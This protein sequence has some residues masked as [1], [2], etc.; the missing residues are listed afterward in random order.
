MQEEI[1]NDILIQ[2]NTNESHFSSNIEELT[3]PQISEIRRRP[4]RNAQ[5]STLNHTELTNEVLLTVKDHFK[6]PQIRDDRFDV[7][8]KNVAIKLRDLS[9]PQRIH[10]EKLINDVLYEGEMGSLTT[11]HKLMVHEPHNAFHNMFRLPYPL[12]MRYDSVTPSTNTSSS[13]I[14]SPLPSY[15]NLMVSSPRNQYQAQDRSFVPISVPQ[16][17]QSEVTPHVIQETVKFS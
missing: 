3:T 12:T 6:Q 14:P 11:S 4:H 5:K 7:F 8:G 17:N 1:Q 2:E 16:T 15:H 10:A 13:D 9:N